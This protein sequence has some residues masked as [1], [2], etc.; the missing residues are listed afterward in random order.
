MTKLDIAMRLCEL[1]K[2]LDRAF[3]ETN[4]HAKNAI[5]QEAADY[6]L[7]LNTEVTV[8]ASNEVIEELTERL[9]V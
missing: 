6:L 7:T 5:I 3:E 8:E 2:I 4:V 1:F 9:G